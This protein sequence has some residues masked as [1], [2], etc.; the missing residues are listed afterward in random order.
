M[1]NKYVENKVHQYHK[2]KKTLMSVQFVYLT[3]FTRFSQETCYRYGV[4]YHN[5][6]SD[7]DVICQCNL[8]FNRYVCINKYI[9]IY[10]YEYKYKTY[11]YI[12]YCFIYVRIFIISL[13]NFMGVY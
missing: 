5:L 11:S 7:I 13:V 9:Y 12:I 8:G 6:N 2:Y 4:Q 3:Y 1:S 10:V